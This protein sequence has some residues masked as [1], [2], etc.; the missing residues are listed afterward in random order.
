MLH[1]GKFDLQLALVGARALGEDVED[2]SRAVNHPPVQALLQ[3]ALLGGT[4]PVIDEHDLGAARVEQLAEFLE[5]ASADQVAGVDL[6]ER[7]GEVRGHLGAG[8]EGQR[9]EFGLG[10]GTG[11]VADAHVDQQ[12]PFAVARPVKHAGAP[13]AEGR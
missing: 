1:L 2:E 4:Q 5:L 10:L 12:G 8:G 6:A 13:A 3:V 11:S 9:L 7:G